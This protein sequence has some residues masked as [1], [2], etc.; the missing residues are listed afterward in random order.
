MSKPT[1]EQL[2]FAKVMTPRQR[3][4]LRALAMFPHHLSAAE[5]GDPAMYAL[6]QM[7]LAQCHS[8]MPEVQGPFLWNATPAGAAIAK[9]QAA[10]SL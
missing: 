2:E 10:G 8:V 5:R 3:G 4:T 1:K 9:L 7:R 6:V